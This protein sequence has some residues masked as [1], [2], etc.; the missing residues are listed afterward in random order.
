MKKYFYLATLA[1]L[2]ACN[3]QPENNNNVVVVDEVQETK[4]VVPEFNGTIDSVS[5][6]KMMVNYFTIKNALID[7]NREAASKT[8][9]GALEQM[10][11]SE[12]DILKRISANF[13]LIGESSELAQQR[14]YFYPLSELVYAVSIKQKPD[15]ATLFKQ[16]CPMA[17]DDTGAW[18][19]SDE[20]EVVNP[21]FGEE[22]LNC[23]MVQEEY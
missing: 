8:G 12:D 2:A 21:Y 3:N 16:F 6:K 9:F 5:L 20:R 22:M 15:T 17:F 13:K 7:G 19:I 14:A 11:K 4:R 23:G 10:P 1:I 18:W